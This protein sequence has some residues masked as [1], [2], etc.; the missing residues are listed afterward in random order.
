MRAREWNRATE[1]EPTKAVINATP[2]AAMKIGEGVRVSLFG[3][4]HVV[5][6]L[7]QRPHPKQEHVG[8]N[9]EI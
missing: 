4:T 2:L 3:R 5:Q 6:A 7:G 8:R 1:Y 9:V